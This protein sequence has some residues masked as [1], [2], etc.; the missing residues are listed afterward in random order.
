MKNVA[1]AILPPNGIGDAKPDN[2][3]V[4]DWVHEIATLTKPE[5]IFWCNGSDRENEFLIAE[6]LK[7]NVLLKLNQKKVPRSYLHR[8]EPN[9]VGRIE[10]FPFVRP[11]TKKQA[12]PTNNWSEPAETYP[13]LRGLLKGAMLGRTMFVIPYMMGPPDSA[14]TKI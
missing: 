6:S 5:N 9:G 10:Q 3:A 2:Q 11:P 1:P 8:S 4:L 7:Q 12:G 14:L 13:K